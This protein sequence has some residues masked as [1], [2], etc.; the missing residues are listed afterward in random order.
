MRARWAEL[1]LEFDAFL[2]PVAPHAA[3]THDPTPDLDART[4]T[5]NGE[6]RPY[7]DQLAWITYASAAY[8]PAVSVPVGTTES[9]LPVGLQVIGPY[10]EDR[11]A[12]DVARRVAELVGGFEAPPAF[13]QAVTAGA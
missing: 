8:L 11:T 1:F 9:R 13:R 2:C 4:I 3:T 10:L 6:P 12:L 7:W 5:I